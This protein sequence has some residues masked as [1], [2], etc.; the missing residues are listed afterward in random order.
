MSQDNV[1]ILRRVFAQ[2][3]E[4]DLESVTAAY[5]EDAVLYGPEGWPEM[6]PWRGREAILGEL[7][8]LWEDFEGDLKIE[9]IEG[10]GEWV[11]VRHLWRVRGNRSGVPGEFRITLAAR[12]R[13]GEVTEA[14][15]FW[16]HEDALEA[17]R[18][19]S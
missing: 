6:G 19:G 16:S 9:E 7:R 8:R 2:A 15:Y 4:G 5:A 13:D 11:L 18:A 10:R 17:A 12:L 14:R 3:N 1:E